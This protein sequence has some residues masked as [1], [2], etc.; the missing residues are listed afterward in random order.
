MEFHLGKTM[1]KT[2]AGKRDEK[3]ARIVM[4]GAKDV[5]KG[6]G[7]ETKNRMDEKK[8]KGSRSR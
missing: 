6:H 7:W 4:A 5:T 3:D 1:V 8:K 2:M